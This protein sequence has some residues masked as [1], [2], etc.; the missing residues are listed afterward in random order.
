MKTTKLPQAESHT[1]HFALLAHS[2]LLMGQ[3]MISTPASRKPAG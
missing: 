1:I 2:P 3:N